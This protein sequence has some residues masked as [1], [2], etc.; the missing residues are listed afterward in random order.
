[1]SKDVGGDSIS[2]IDTTAFNGLLNN[3][4][5]TAMPMHIEDDVFIHESAA[6]GTDALVYLSSSLHDVQAVTNHYKL[7]MAYETVPLLAGLRSN[8][9]RADVVSAASFSMYPIMPNMQ[10]SR[11]QKKILESIIRGVV[12]GAVNGRKFAEGAIPHYASNLQV[13]MFFEAFRHNRKGDWFY[14]EEYA[15]TMT[16]EQMEE[17]YNYNIE[18]IGDYYHLGQFIEDQAY[19]ESIKYGLGDSNMA[20]SG[21]EI[22]AIVNALT[23]MGIYLSSEQFAELI[24]HFESDGM[25]YNGQFGTS[26]VAIYQYLKSEGYDVEFTLSTKSRDI[27]QISNEYPTFIVSAFNNVDN[28][29][30]AVHTVCITKEPE[31]YVVHNGYRKRGEKYIASEAY[32]TLE[33]AINHIAE[34]GNSKVVMIMGV[35]P[36]PIKGDLGENREKSC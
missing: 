16:E 15:N 35:K 8:L 20:Y 36:S 6:V 5:T 34:D 9:V 4:V 18:H 30:D 7:H 17:H 13:I 23:N 24:K 32:P 26:P 29:K 14:I 33:E 22:I 31:G 25:C 11:I 27:E 21:C 1:M 19:W 12:S 10:P 28:V 2:S 3:L